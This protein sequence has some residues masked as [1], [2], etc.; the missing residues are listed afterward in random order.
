MSLDV[1]VAGAT[2]RFG[3]V[4]GLLLERGHGVRALTR[5]P[6]SAAAHRLEERGARIVRGDYDDPSSLAAAALGADAVSQAAPR[7]GLGRTASCV[8]G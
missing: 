2:G 7:T 4:A 8:T 3:A 6:E 5:D 1:L